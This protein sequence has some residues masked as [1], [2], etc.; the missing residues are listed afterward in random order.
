MFTLNDTCW[1]LV[2]YIARAEAGLP[3]VLQVDAAETVAGKI[4]S[5]AADGGLS[6]EA[7]ENYR[8]AFAT[9]FDRS[10]AVAN[11]IDAEFAMCTKLL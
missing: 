7:T 4:V 11:M 6:A 10:A 8:T 9:I 1:M 2:V 3:F 5:C